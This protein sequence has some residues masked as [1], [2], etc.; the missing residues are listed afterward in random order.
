MRILSTLLLVLSSLSPFACARDDKPERSEP[1]L[2]NEASLIQRLA[3]NAESLF[4]EGEFEKVGSECDKALALLDEGDPR[5]EAISELREQAQR[6]LVRDEIRIQMDEVLAL[7]RTA[8]ESWP[9]WKEARDRWESVID[10]IYYAGWIEGLD[11]LLE[12]AQNGEQRCQIEI[13]KRRGDAKVDTRATLEEALSQFRERWNALQME[14]ATHLEQGRINKASAT[15]R[16]LINCDPHHKT[17]IEV[18]NL[19]KEGAWDQLS[20]AEQTELTDS[21]SATEK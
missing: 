20:E 14:A 1:L 16:R 18:S 13:E 10:L 21:L 17:A 5:R 6:A 4:H 9:K 19:I 8:T 12:E 15:L 11:D 7:E 3:S 2:V